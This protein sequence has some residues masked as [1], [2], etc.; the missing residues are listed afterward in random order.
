MTSN[1]RQF[2][3]TIA[4]ASAVTLL[5]SAQKQLA[6]PTPISC[7]SYNW[8]TF[9][10]RK[11]KTWEEDMDTCFA[12]FAKTGI[13]AYEPG[14]N[15]ANHVKKLAPILQK[16][17]IKLPSVYVNSVLHKADDANK[18]IESVLAIAEEVQRLG[19]KIMVTNPTPI[20]WGGD[21]IK[22]D[23]ELETQLKSL[24]KLGAELRKKGIKL[25]YHTHD[26]EMRAGAREFHHMLQNTSP[27]N[28]H[29]CFDVHWAFRGSQDSH[30][31]VFDVLKMYGKRVVELHIRQSVNG[32][33][34][35]TF[36]DGDID[37]KRLASEFKKLNMKPHLVIEQCI[38]AKTPDTMDG[39]AAHIKDLA[40]IKEVFKP[41]LG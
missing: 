26:V 19:T 21:E 32:V 6:Y 15:D 33:W 20:R 10:R 35:E 23:V 30:L 25:A 14:L 39:V 40:M 17:N 34:T 8:V 41:L 36:G 16:Y 37:Y 28:V 3:G 7:N 9:Y 38:E 18:S 5:S 31:A 29:F 24:D 2:L 12:E 13:P 1:R 4:G 22:S 27:E 11:S